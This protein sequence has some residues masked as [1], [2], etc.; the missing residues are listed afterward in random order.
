MHV[1]W[2]LVHG[3]AVPALVKGSVFDTG[4]VNAELFAGSPG[5]WFRLNIKCNI[6]EVLNSEQSGNLLSLLSHSVYDK[7][8]HLCPFD[9]G[10]IERNIELYFSGAVKPI[11][12][13]NPCLDG[14]CLSVQSWGRHR[15]AWHPGTFSVCVLRISPQAWETQSFV[16]SVESWQ[17][18][19]RPLLSGDAARAGLLPWRTLLGYAW[20]WGPHGRADSERKFDSL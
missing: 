14:K 9:T 16:P 15:P 5:C 3:R 1:A 2:S 17:S 7:K 13:D 20:G 8:G 4:C 19:E 18:E 12:D 11:Y 10:L 6:L